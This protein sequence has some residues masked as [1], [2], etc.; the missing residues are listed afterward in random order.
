MSISHR[1]LGPLA[2]AALVVLAG[3]SAIGGGDPPTA[4]PDSAVGTPTDAATGTAAVTDTATTADDGV[5]AE[6]TEDTPT[7]TAT[8]TPTPPPTVTV[9][10]ETGIRV[11]EINADAEGRDT[12]NLNDE[13][14]VLKNTGDLALDLSGWRVKDDDGHVYEFRDGFTL[15]IGATVT[16]HSGSGTQ[17]EDHRFWWADEPVWDNGG[18]TIS[19]YDDGGR[20]VYERSY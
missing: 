3:C 14:I 8:A 16:L 19:I 5:E 2:L 11:V 12:N 1:T 7:P 15:D 20:K 9:V 10:S 17:T 4:S 6:G 13:Y 18:D